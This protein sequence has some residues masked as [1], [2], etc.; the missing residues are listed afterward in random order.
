MVSKPRGYKTNELF[1]AHGGMCAADG[2][3]W[4]V[5]DFQQHIE[6]GYLAAIAEACALAITANPPDFCLAAVSAGADVV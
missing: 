2:Q 1:T 6:S 5:Y 3:S 4:T